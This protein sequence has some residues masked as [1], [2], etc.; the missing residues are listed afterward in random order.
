MNPL[1][2]GVSTLSLGGLPPD[3]KIAFASLK[4]C[5]VAPLDL[6]D[7]AQAL[8]LRSY[9]WPEHSFRFDRLDVAIAAA[10]Q[11]ALRKTA[12]AAAAA[13]GGDDDAATRLLSRMRVSMNAPRRPAVQQ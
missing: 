11:K 10:R 1:E 7:P 2:T 8:R 9:I 13:G 12:V 5:D 6:T 4:G 3:R